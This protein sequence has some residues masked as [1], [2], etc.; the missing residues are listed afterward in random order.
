MI[1]MSVAMNFRT[2]ILIL[3]LTVCT[4]A[5]AAIYTSTVNQIIPDNNANGFQNTLTINN[6]PSGSIVTDINVTLN[7]SGGYN[8]DLYGYLVHDSGF[9]VLLN[10]VGSSGSNPDGY[11]D[12]GFHITL[13]DSAGTSVHDYQTVT[14]TL[15]A[16]SALTGTWR[17]D[18]GSLSSFNGLSANG[19][20]TLFFAD[21]SAGEQSTLQS[22]SIEVTSVPEPTTC[23]AIIFGGLFGMGGCAR[24]VVRKVRQGAALPSD[25]P[26]HGPTR[27]R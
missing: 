16:S 21:T 5:E 20:W 13:D 19:G 10:H 12:Q 9:V 6:L 22:W 15:D 27:A 24:W 4:S 2:A 18:G 14:Y 3:L 7:I 23:A 11:A 26:P 25:V 17:A 8:G 1:K